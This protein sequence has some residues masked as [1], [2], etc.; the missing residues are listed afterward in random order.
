M[1]WRVVGTTTR[2]LVE[3]GPYV[4][5]ISDAGVVAY[6]A[7]RADGST[8]VV[9]DGQVVDLAAESHPDVN[10][11]GDLSAYTR[12]GVVRGA[13]LL[14][15]HHGPLGPT[16]NNRGDVAWRSDTSVHINDA[17]VARGHF[18]GLPVVN[19]AGSVAF[20]TTLSDGRHAIYLDDRLVVAA[21]TLGRFPS[22]NHGGTVVFVSPHAVHRWR[23][24]VVETLHEGWGY[25]G[26][27][28]DD[29]GRVVFYATPPGGT[30]GIYARGER[31]LGG[32]FD[33]TPI[34]EFAL[35]PVSINAA[36]E[37]V[38]RVRLEDG[39]QLIMRG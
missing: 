27:L 2:D 24:G 5:A 10:T 22:L 36:G 13:T 38:V 11:R 9:V 15:P 25:R 18:E 16:M 21:P 14:S 29:E 20:R 8:A 33:G 37:V 34:R 1:D 23:D 12:G 19:D 35:N 17:E 30:L 3:L 32:S 28:V 4:P 31:V 26:A 6:T 7:T 39:R